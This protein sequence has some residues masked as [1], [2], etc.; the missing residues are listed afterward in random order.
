[1]S[2]TQD[3]K[4][5]VIK[6]FLLILLSCILSIAYNKQASASTTTID[7]S[8]EGLSPNNAS[9]NYQLQRILDKHMKTDTTIYVPTGT[10]I[11]N[12][13]DI[14]LHS[15]LHFE[16]AD[17]AVFKT[18]NG[19]ALYFVYPSFNL[20]YNGGL[21]NISWQNATFVGSDINGQS[22]IT[23]SFNHAQNISF[24]K[25]KFYNVERPNGHLLDIDGS[26]NISVTNSTIL[27]CNL[28][29]NTAY[30]EA[31]QIDYSN[32][33]A[34]SCRINGDKY[35]NLP[36]YNIYINNN[37]FLPITDS[38]NHIK[39]FAPNPIGQHALYNNGKAGVIHHI[40]FTNNEVVDPIPR[41]DPDASTI[42]FMGI[43]SLFITD[44]RFVNIN[45]SGASNYIRIVNPIQNYK[46]SN[47]IISNNEFLNVKPKRF[48]ITLKSN[49]AYSPISNITISNNQII[50]FS[51][52]S[53][54]I[55]SQQNHMEQFN[56]QIIQSMQQ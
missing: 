56:N 5:L 55:F 37:H 12:T 47:V 25:C 43:N 1:M 48:F 46:M 52:V 31:I 15:N 16:F 36:S 19:N 33:F 45:T 2:Q 38:Q 4:P 42:N 20:G 30:K 7:A 27:G 3:S 11:F 29:P 6:V 44:N 41:T 28:T 35:D 17:N 40:F 8:H 53:P 26:R 32:Y 24:N 50:N 34:T 39:F 18:Q 23:Q 9:N 51:K 21:Q 22:S 54:F 14:V 10:Y 49:N 13:G